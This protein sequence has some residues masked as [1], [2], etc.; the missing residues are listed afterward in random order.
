MTQ[1]TVTKCIAVICLLAAIVCA[2]FGVYD[3]VVSPLDRVKEAAILIPAAV[4]L[5]VI[6]VVLWK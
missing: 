3:L 6:Y 2:L 1:E 5:V 4:F